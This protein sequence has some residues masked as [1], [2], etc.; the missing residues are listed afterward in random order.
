MSLEKQLALNIS[1]L[2]MEIIYIINEFAFIDQTTAFIKNKKRELNQ[3]VKNAVYSRKNTSVWT[4]EQSKTWLFAVYYED[5]T[6]FQLE[7]GTAQIVD[8]IL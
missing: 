1:V 2:P 5:M 4:T 3:V 6:Y 7:S 8:N